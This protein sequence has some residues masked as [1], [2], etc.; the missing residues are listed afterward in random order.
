[1]VF[2]VKNYGWVQVCF[3]LSLGLVSGLGLEGSVSILEGLITAFLDC[4][5]GLLVEE[6]SLDVVGC[7]SFYV[8][9]LVIKFL[10]EF[11]M[12]FYCVLGQFLLGIVR[13]IESILYK[14]RLMKIIIPY[15]FWLDRW[16]TWRPLLKHILRC[17]SSWEF[18]KI[19]D[20]L[21][22]LLKFTPLKLHLLL[23]SPLLAQISTPLD[24]ILDLLLQLH[25]K[26]ILNLLLLLSTHALSHE[27]KKHLGSLLLTQCP[28][29]LLHRQ[30]T[31]PLHIYWLVFPVDVYV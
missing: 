18:V 15:E 4:H 22:H 21:P 9:W 7:I 20:L 17:P 10:I 28:N 8:R 29:L 12:I 19:L 1:M 25:I 5:W 27:V 16:Y 3:L 31:Q 14:I 26:V 6:L 2:V 23:K 30:L 13:V 11:H 24:I